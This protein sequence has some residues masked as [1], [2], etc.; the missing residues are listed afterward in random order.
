[1]HDKRYKITDEGLLFSSCILY[2]LSPLE[3]L[4][5]RPFNVVLYCSLKSDFVK[6]EGPGTD[7][8]RVVLRFAE[9]SHGAHDSLR[10]LLVEEHTHRPLL[11]VFGDIAAAIGD[12]GASGCERLD[13]HDAEVLLLREHESLALCILAWEVFFRHAPEKFDRRSGHLLQ[14]LE[15]R[16]A[17]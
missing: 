1:M 2:P 8:M 6:R 5:K 13:R 10:R 14:A 16:T 7:S 3:V 4:L 17:A 15:F 11:H 9:M 12:E